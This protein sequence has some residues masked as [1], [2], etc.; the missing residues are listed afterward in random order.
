MKK[1]KFLLT[2]DY[3][4][5]MGACRDYEKGIFEP[6]DKILQLAKKLNVPIVLF[7][8]ICS[9]QMFKEW[10]YQN[11][12]KPF[13]NQLL[14]ALRGNHDVQL[15]IHPH[16][17]VSEYKKGKYIPSPKL[18]LDAFEN[19]TSP[20]DISGIIKEAIQE[21]HL[22]CREVRP[23]YQCIAY[24]AG[25]YSIQ[26]ATDKIF[27]ALYDNGIRIDSS[28]VKG[29]FWK[30]SELNV[31]YR[32][33]YQKNSWFINLNGE[34]DKEATHGIFEIPVT[35][36]P[37]FLKQ[38]I[39]RIKKKI[40][41]KRK[42][43]ELAYNHTGLGYAG[44]TASGTK[45]KILNAV[46]SPLVLSFDN[47]TT[48]IKLIDQIISYNLKKHKGEES[49]ILCANSHPKCFGIHQLQLFEDSVKLIQEKY[50]NLI[51][52][53]TFDEIYKQDKLIQK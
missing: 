7:A 10:D 20:S 31:D 32:K 27:Q 39:D 2:F 1:I 36:M 28:V 12:Y 15:H 19:E 52:F 18:G 17:R 3:E 13:K 26:P 45:Y 50:A 16:W 30:T 41:N 43:R 29:L 48:D 21:L 9:A 8:D 33:I 4:L 38:R 40:K 6:S 37:T 53:T 49:I 44:T 25:C 11:F 35:T 22:I 23:D 14:N 47:L 5:P 34:L 51:E 46:Y 42:Y 24:R